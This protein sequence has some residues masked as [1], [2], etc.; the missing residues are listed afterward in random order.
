MVDLRQP[1]E[2]ARDCSA[3]PQS[4]T[5]VFA[6]VAVLGT[7]SLGIVASAASWSFQTTYLLLGGPGFVAMT[8]CSHRLWEPHS[9]WQLR[10]PTSYVRPLRGP[11]MR[12]RVGSRT[13]RCGGRADPQSPPLTCRS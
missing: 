3:R 12:S 1:G 10:V 8:I 11:R 4:L 13:N 7:L 6:S 9:L 5:R 2:Q